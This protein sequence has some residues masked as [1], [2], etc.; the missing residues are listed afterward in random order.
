MAAREVGIVEQVH[1]ARTHLAFAVAR[2]R[3]ADRV[4]ERAEKDGKS[5]GLAKQLEALVEDGDAV[6]LHL[7]D[8]RCVRAARETGTHLICGGV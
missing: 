2:D 1:I 6:I 8:D 7:V 4:F 3:D 5:G